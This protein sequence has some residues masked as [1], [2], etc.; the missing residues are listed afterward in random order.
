[1]CFLYPT[2]IWFRLSITAIYPCKYNT[3]HRT[4][5]VQIPIQLESGATCI[6][7]H[8]HLSCVEHASL[9]LPI[10]FWIE[11]SYIFHRT[12]HFFSLIIISALP[13]QQI[14]G[15]Q[16]CQPGGSWSELSTTGRASSNTP[17]VENQLQCRHHSFHRDAAKAATYNL[18]LQIQLKVVHKTGHRTNR[19]PHA[20]EF[21]CSSL[22]VENHQA[23]I[24]H[25]TGVCREP[26]DQFLGARNCRPAWST[27]VSVPTVRKIKCHDIVS[28][29]IFTK[30][31]SDKHRQ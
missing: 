31:F 9:R 27:G 29:G 14:M 5:F 23:S 30:E 2:H 20:M 3:Q 8:Q 25:F 16:T 22:E 24:L 17:P 10:P 4:D 11:A 19:N 28:S 13:H 1:M 21:K 7:N 26:C 12:S 15:Q 18:T 6:Y